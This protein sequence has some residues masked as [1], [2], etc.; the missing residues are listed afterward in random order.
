MFSKNLVAMWR[1]TR[2]L[3]KK[4]FKETHFQS[5]L[6]S[7]QHKINYEY[8]LYI[9]EII[10]AERLTGI[11]QSCLLDCSCRACFPF[12]FTMLEGSD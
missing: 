8:K 1:L 10:L 4:F 11:S 7:I 9:K 5:A 2:K 12:V 3:C 6:L